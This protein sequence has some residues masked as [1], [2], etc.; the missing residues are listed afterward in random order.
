MDPK[1][2][3]LHFDIRLPLQVIAEVIKQLLCGFFIWFFARDLD[4]RL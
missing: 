4:G 1:D 3:F 2:A